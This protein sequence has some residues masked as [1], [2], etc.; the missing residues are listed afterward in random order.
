LTMTARLLGHYDVAVV[1]GGPAGSVAAL[2][3]ARAGAAV[4]LL[5]RQTRHERRL[6]ETL[7]PAATRILQQLSVWD[8]FLATAPVPAY[9]N[10]SAWGSDELRFDDF[11]FGTQGPGWHIDRGRFEAMLCTSAQRAGTTVLHDSP[12]KSLHMNGRGCRLHFARDCSLHTA[13][14]DFL[15]DASGRGRNRWQPHSERRQVDSLIGVA[16]TARVSAAR[17]VSSYTLVE[18][19]YD[20]WF[21]SAQVSTTEIVACYLTDAD[22]YARARRSGSYFQSRL[23]RAPHTRQR[24]EA[25]TAVSHPRCAVAGSSLRATAAGENWIAI[26][27]AAFSCDPLSA[28]GLITAVESG[29]HAANIIAKTGKPSL[30]SWSGYLSTAFTSYLAQRKQYYQ[31]EQRWPA[32]A[33]WQR[34]QQPAADLAR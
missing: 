32:S 9:A 22:L 25:A 21:Y 16:L 2:Q 34:R 7:P 14:A 18:S 6:G 17:E 26:G 28:S 11:I 24:L 12:I 20:G 27:D 8:E 1:G 23:A 31:M 4:L 15:I 19:V 10:A 13:N 29:V 33:F 30:H 3:L 5:E